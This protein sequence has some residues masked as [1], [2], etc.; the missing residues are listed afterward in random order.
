MM[1]HRIVALG[2]VLLSLATVRADDQS[3]AAI[4]TN[5]PKGRPAALPRR[6]SIIYLNCQGLA[7]GDLSCYGQTNFQTPNL[8]RLA[9]EGIRFTHYRTAGDDLAQA[10]AALVTGSTNAFAAEATTLPARLRAVGYHTGLI[11]EWPL[12]PQPWTQG[13]DEF[14]GYLSEAE[15]DNYYA[16]YMW[17]YAPNA[18]RNATN[19]LRHAWVGREEIHD[20]TGG[21]KSKFIPDLLLTAAGNFI[22]MNVP[23][24][25]NHYRPFFLLVNLPE[26]HSVTAGKDD[27][28][29]PTDAPYSDE[30]WPQPAKNRAA[31]VTRLD[32][33]VGRLLEQLKKLN[34]TNNVVIVLSG[35][36]APGKFADARLNF[37]QIPGELRGGDTA[38]RLRVPLIVR[39]PGHVPAGTINSAPCEAPDLAATVLQIA[40]AKPP[41]SFTGASLL[42]AWL[43]ARG[44]PGPVSPGQPPPLPAEK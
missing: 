39:W 41:A 2:A 34:L 33:N 5:A 29:V 9:A 7:L 3:L 19:N 17:R 40:Y 30:P 6:A 25:A 18:A 11:G 42:P 38:D 13:F 22:R 10:Q 23:D 21:R 31:T 35:A 26:P 1:I 32:A 28:P 36:A 20:N 8:D 4:F 24:F 44:T 14:A 15:A 37:L 27:Y 12:G 43:G 16:D